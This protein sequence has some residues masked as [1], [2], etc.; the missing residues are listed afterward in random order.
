MKVGLTPRH[1]ACRWIPRRPPGV[2]I[3]PWMDERT[4]R[5]A[6]AIRPLLFAWLPAIAWA[7][8]IF[9]FSAQPDLRFVPDQGL[10]FLVRKAGHMAVF[11]ILA[12]LL[13]RAVAGT[14]AWRRP[15]AWAVAL[16]VLYAASD[17]LHQGFV[18]GRHPSPVD[19]GIDA[20]GALIAIVAVGIVQSRRA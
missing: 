2:G 14:T 1:A 8:L 18:A 3:V 17:E 5:P 6:H 9:A 4:P 11:G 13:W 20:T 10:D 19:V 16:A 15:W 7:G 12:L